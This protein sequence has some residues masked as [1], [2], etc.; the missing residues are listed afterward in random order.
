MR[1]PSNGA[2]AVDNKYCKLLFYR[3]INDDDYDAVA[4]RVAKGPKGNSEDVRYW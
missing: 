1:A 2:P 3:L 4:V